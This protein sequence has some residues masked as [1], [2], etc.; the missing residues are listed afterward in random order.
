[1]YVD[2]ALKAYKDG[3]TEADPG[4]GGVI[5]ESASALSVICHC[6]DSEEQAVSE[7]EARAKRFLDEISNWY[8]A[9]SEASP[10]YEAMAGLKPIVENKVSLPEITQRSPYVTVG[11]ADLFIERAARLQE[12]G[13]NEWIM[14]MDGLL[15]DQIMHS[16][17]LV[18]KHVIPACS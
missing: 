5:N 12:A 16:L 18:G 9:L 17:E 14:T 3:L 4:P 8:K 13:Y 2:E 1:D 15:H 10:E 6:A 7:V 11:T